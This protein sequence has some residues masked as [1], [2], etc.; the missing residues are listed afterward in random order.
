MPD[1][2]AYID[3][4]SFANQLADPKTRLL[5]QQMLGAEV[6]GMGERARVGFAE[7]VFNR[8]RIQ[9]KTL[10]QILRDKGYY[11][12]Y[13]KW[14]GGLARVRRNWT[15]GKAATYDRAIQKAFQGS[16]ITRGATHNASGSV[17]RQWNTKFQGAPGTRIDYGG[18]TFYSKVGEQR[19][20][21]NLVYGGAQR[22]PFNASLP[23]AG[24][25]LDA[26]PSF[27]PATQLNAAGGFVIPGQGDQSDTMNWLQD[28]QIEGVPGA[29]RTYPTPSFGSRMDA[30]PGTQ[31]YS[32]P[33]VPKQDPTA[34]SKALGKG[35]DAAI[36]A[37]RERHIGRAKEYGLLPKDKPVP[38]FTTTT[39]PAVE[40]TP[41]QVYGKLPFNPPAAETFNAVDPRPP[42]APPAP[43]GPDLS[44]K[45]AYAKNAAPIKPGSMRPEFWSREQYQ[46]GPVPSPRALSQG[47]PSITG[48]DIAPTTPA[49]PAQ[50][51]P[52]PIAQQNPFLNPQ[53]N[54]LP[55]QPLT[56][57]T[58]LPPTPIPAPLSAPSGTTMVAG[59]TP[60]PGGGALGAGNPKNPIGSAFGGLAKIFAGQE[61]AKAA[62]SQQATAQH[63][64]MAQ[65]AESAM[66]QA[67]DLQQARA[68]Q[69]MAQFADFKRRAEEEERQ[70]RMAAHQGAWTARI[71]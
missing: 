27:D 11:Q 49:P 14:D 9:G 46:P 4:R 12:P 37:I 15:D 40:G 60:A 68:T 25:Q 16:N 30:I 7:T 13:R 71:I 66:S 50:P 35:S 20:I 65:A 44:N 6:G 42:P 10:S 19:K 59:A 69:Q 70:R 48:G 67:N 38:G 47:H 52:A 43:P 53:L 58:P 22:S 5:F 23:T 33:T 55:S 32:D 56:L 39:P 28:L 29:G 45:P 51:N 8:A 63:N 64:K 24:D 61:K 2:N 31:V 57:P 36:K 17:A 18:E 62:M 1:P 34:I 26:L 21:S 41:N 3:R 54:P